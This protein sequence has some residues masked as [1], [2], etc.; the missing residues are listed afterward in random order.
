M[1]AKCGELVQSP[2]SADVRAATGAL[3][4]RIDVRYA[5]DVTVWWCP[6][7]QSMDLRRGLPGLRRHRLQ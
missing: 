1:R 4:R 5:E 7:C 3:T 6:L 2:L